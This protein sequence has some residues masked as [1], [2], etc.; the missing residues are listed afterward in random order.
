MSF[1]KSNKALG[2]LCFLLLAKLQAQEKYMEVKAFFDQSQIQIGEQ[3]NYIIQARSIDTIF[4]FST[5]YDTVT[6]L[7]KIGDLE[8]IKSETQR[9]KEKD[10]YIVNKKYLV[11]HFD[12]G[13]YT[14]PK[15]HTY[16]NKYKFTAPRATLVVLEPSI[17]T[18]EVKIYDIRQVADDGILEASAETSL[19][20]WIVVVIT[21][22]VLYGL[23]YLFFKV[24][25]LSKKKQE[26]PVRKKV[27]KE[28]SS[29]HTQLLEKKNYN[30]YYT[31]VTDAFRL[32]IDSE[33]NI[34]AMEYTSHQLLRHLQANLSDYRIREVFNKENIKRLSE[35]FK[36]SDLAKFAKMNFDKQTAV[37][38][39]KFLLES[40]QKVDDLLEEDR[41][42]EEIIKEIQIK[43]AKKN[44]FLW[45][46]AV[47]IFT[48]LLSSLTI[49][50]LDKSYAYKVYRILG[51]DT[52]YL[53]K[54]PW[55]SASYGNPPTYLRTPEYLKRQPVGDN[56]NVEIFSLGDASK[57]LWIQLVTQQMQLPQD[58]EKDYSD[59]VYQVKESI[60][61]IIENVGGTEIIESE[62]DITGS[63]YF[64]GFFNLDGVIKSY[65]IW[66][67]I[68][69]SGVTALSIVFDKEDKTL[70]EMA[71]SIQ[72]SIE[73][74][75]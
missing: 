70:G 64:S 1:I 50:S 72:K 51:M 15:V 33:L 62:A 29:D 30:T 21:L 14:V 35:V 16:V 69:E 28:L 27:I 4:S 71:R 40:I 67:G 18:T 34:P 32:Y 57:N 47:V 3:I 31:K 37:L 46:A 10:Q 49:I 66:V 5:E 58:G 2:I 20:L 59:L 56:P 55:V 25:T 53:K 43:R 63:S 42:K 61:R 13:V 68:L 6:Y 45:F 22:F 60:L 17:D 12:Q 52:E 74:E 41:K 23:Y 9:S 44:K 39:Q 11:T 7:E 75:E 8:V 38:D 54:K 48:L 24:E 19:G 73:T 65:K 26:E 36:A